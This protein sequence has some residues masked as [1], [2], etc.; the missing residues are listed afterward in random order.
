MNQQPPNIGE[1]VSIFPFPWEHFSLGKIHKNADNIDISRFSTLYFLN[2]TCRTPEI[3]IINNLL[4]ENGLF[5]TSATFV[6][7]S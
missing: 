1:Y 3:I 4:T 5:K 2:N 6:C 7:K